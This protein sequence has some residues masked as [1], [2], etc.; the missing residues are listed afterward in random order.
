MMIVVTVT[1]ESAG[2]VVGRLLFLPI[3]RGQVA[4]IRMHQVEMPI[5]EEVDMEEVHM[6]AELQGY[7]LDQ[8]D[9][10]KVVL[11]FLWVQDQRDNHLCV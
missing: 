8:E 11:D 9:R 4:T 1:M 3:H 10:D 6:Q 5:P 2:L 7:L